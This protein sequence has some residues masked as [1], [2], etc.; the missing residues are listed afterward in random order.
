MNMADMLADFVDLIVAM[1][2]GQP[3]RNESN[4]FRE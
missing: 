2:N 3:A 4:E 1:T